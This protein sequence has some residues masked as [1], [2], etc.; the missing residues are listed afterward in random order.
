MAY[1]NDNA[2]LDTY[3]RR[4]P[5][6][7]DPAECMTYLLGW[8]QSKRRCEAKLDHGTLSHPERLTTQA[9]LMAEE[10]AIEQLLDALAETKQGR[11]VPQRT[12]EALEELW[13][14]AET[15]D[16]FHDTD[17]DWWQTKLD[18]EMVL[19]PHWF[20]PNEEGRGA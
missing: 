5:T 15:F 20:G 3:W 17:H 4:L 16:E 7:D 8:W 13:A 19:Y 9:L 2:Q 11:A 14:C 6:T 18:V 10:E 1:I 12:R